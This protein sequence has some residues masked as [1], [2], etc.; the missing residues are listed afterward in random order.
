MQDT[1]PVTVKEA[2]AQYQHL[3]REEDLAGLDAFMSSLPEDIRSAVER[4]ARS[5]R[6]LREHLVARLARKAA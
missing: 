6:W 3:F 5:Y 2:Y 1:I 4:T